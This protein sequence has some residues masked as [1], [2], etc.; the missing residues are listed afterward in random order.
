MREPMCCDQVARGLLAASVSALLLAGCGPDLGPCSN[1]LN[2]TTQTAPYEGQ[3]LIN[4]SCAGGR[5]HSATATGELRQGVPADLNFDLVPRDL[6]PAEISKIRDGAEVVFDNREEIWSQIESGNMPPPPPAGGAALNNAEKETIR[7]WLACGAPFYAA[8][9]EMAPVPAN[10]TDIYEALVEPAQMCVG[11]HG[12]NPM[13]G[14]GFMLG[15][16]GDAC[17]AY[18]RVVGAQAITTMPFMPPAC[19]GMGQLVVPNNP[20]QS[21]LLRKIE[22]ASQICGSPMP[23]GDPNGLGADNPLVMSLRSWIMAG[24]PKPTNCP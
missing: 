12:A 17:A 2:G 18:T 9:E 19:V 20:T 6:T 8:P 23:L 11:C 4:N 13:S 7:N 15:V 1:P 22:G 16:S 5:C 14:D 24:A 3:A 10:W 21:I